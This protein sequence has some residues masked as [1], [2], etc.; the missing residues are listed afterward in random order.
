MWWFGHVTCLGQ[1]INAFILVKKLERTRQLERLI[2]RWEDNIKLILK[3][4]GLGGA[5]W[6]YQ[7]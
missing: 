3:K 4:L 1:I 7:A 6:I 2:H 5:E